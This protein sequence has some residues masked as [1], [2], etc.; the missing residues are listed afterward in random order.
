MSVAETFDPNT[1]KLSPR[2]VEKVRD[3]VLEEENDDLDVSAKS[4]DSALSAST[5]VTESDVSVPV[6]AKPSNNKRMPGAKRVNR[7]GSHED[8]QQTEA[9][10]KKAGSVT[11][12][13]SEEV[14]YGSDRVRTSYFVQFFIE[15]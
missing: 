1:I 7:Q 4:G 11:S 13:D 2:A 14:G 9:G 8:Q 15:S 10:L 5:N 3:L 6:F 12:L